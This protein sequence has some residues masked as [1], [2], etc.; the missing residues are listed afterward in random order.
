MAWLGSMRQIIV[1]IDIYIVYFA[2]VVV[3][4]ALNMLNN[5]SSKI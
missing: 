2:I 5:I 1:R 4:D 3:H